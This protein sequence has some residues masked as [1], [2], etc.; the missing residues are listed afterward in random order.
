MT[1]RAP[2]LPSWPRQLLRGHRN[3]RTPIRSAKIHAAPEAQG[4]RRPA[5]PGREA[6]PAA[7]RVGAS[8]CP[9]SRTPGLDVPK[10]LL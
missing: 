2:P 8:H 5:D 1:D 7:A 6:E 9:D 10:R 4:M 3:P